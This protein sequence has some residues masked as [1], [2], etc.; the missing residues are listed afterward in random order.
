MPR[1]LIE[2]IEDKISGRPYNLEKYVRIIDN[3]AVRVYKSRYREIGIEVDRKLSHPEEVIRNQTEQAEFKLRDGT[4]L[5]NF[6]IFRN[7]CWDRLETPE[8]QG[9]LSD[10]SAP[11]DGFLISYISKSFEHLLQRKIDELTPGFE[12]RKKQIGR[13]LKPECLK[14][15]RTLCQCWKLKRHKGISLK[16]ATEQQLRDTALTKELPQLQFP[17]PGSKYGPR[18]KDNEMRQY[19]ADVLQKAGGMTTKNNMISF[20][21]GQYDFKTIKELIPTPEGENDNEF[22]SGPGSGYIAKTALYKE[23][24]F[25]SYDQ[26]IMARELIKSMNQEEK[27]IVYLRFVKEKKFKEISDKMGYSTASAHNAVSNIVAHFQRYFT[28]GPNPATFEE[29]EAV[30]GLVCG[31]IAEERAET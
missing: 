2:L 14:S 12:T 24:V 7:L 8:F 31:L 25:V 20:I 11:D 16:P 28:S 18:I 21:A 19:L 9:F 15:C 26:M 13:V 6:E 17:K 4:L 29:G 3:V 10:F 22:P 1:Q 30:I 23:Y 5:V 27:E